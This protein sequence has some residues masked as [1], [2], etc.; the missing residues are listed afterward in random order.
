M[1]FRNIVTNNVSNK[2]IVANKNNKKE[3][4]TQVSSETESAWQVFWFIST[5]PG[6][7][8]EKRLNKPSTILSWK[9]YVS[10]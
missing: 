3:F 6:N 10:I 1:G 9:N 8:H 4:E 5:A 7:G 2:E